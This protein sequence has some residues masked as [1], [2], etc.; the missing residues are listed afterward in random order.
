MPTPVGPVPSDPND[1]DSWAEW[2]DTEED[3]GELGSRFGWPLRLVAV[4]IVIAIVAL[5]VLAT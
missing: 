1:P 4:V 2:Y 5:F 3:D